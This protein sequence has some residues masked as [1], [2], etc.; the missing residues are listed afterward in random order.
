MSFNTGPILAKGSGDGAVC[1]YSLSATDVTIVN[2]EGASFAT[3]W[4]CATDWPL[5]S[6]LNFDVGVANNVIAPI[7]NNGEVCFYTNV[8]SDVIVD[9]VGYFS[10]T[11]ADA[12]VGSAPKRFLD[13]RDGTGRGRGRGNFKA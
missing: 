5:T 10:G 9:I 6:S 8:E 2:P 3:A 11:G 7:D 12:F 4:P 1:V 13:T